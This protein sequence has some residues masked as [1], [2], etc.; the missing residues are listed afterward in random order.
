MKQSVALL[1]MLLLATGCSKGVSVQ[2]KV[3][4]ED[5]TPLTQGEVRFMS[6]NKTFAGSIQKDG[7]FVMM[8]TT[9]NSG[10]EA[11][12]YNVAITGAFEVIKKDANDEYGTTKSLIEKKF[13]DPKESGL[14]CNVEKSMTVEFKVSPPGASGTKP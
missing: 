8:G 3:V 4:F 1:M 14:T 6:D 11:G 5:G 10:I 2:G 12:T 13:G 9:P 7:T